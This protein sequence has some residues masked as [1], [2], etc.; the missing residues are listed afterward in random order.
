[1]SDRC[2]ITLILLSLSFLLISCQKAD[3]RPI[4]LKAPQDIQVKSEEKP[5]ES[6]I[7]ISGTEIPQVKKFPAYECRVYN[8]YVVFLEPTTDSP[9]DYITV[10]LRGPIEDKSKLCSM[11]SKDK[12]YST[13][14]TELI[15]IYGD[16]LFIDEG[17]CPG[18]RGLSIDSLSE[19]KEIYQTS[20]SDH[21]P[22]I[23]GKDLKLIFDRVNCVV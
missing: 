14:G 3:E 9:D 10:T 6:F 18:T 12:Y 7:G 16:Y 11:D 8:K 15:G 2:A 5:I 22:I 21:Y 20:Y 13:S 19:K 17:C 1:M 4:E 23:L